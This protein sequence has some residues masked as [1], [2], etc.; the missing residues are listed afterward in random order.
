MLSSV[1]S[2]SHI[3]LHLLNRHRSHGALQTV[4]LVGG[5]K[6]CR[7]PRDHV[8][9]DLHYNTIKRLV[10]SSEVREHLCSALLF[11]LPP[12]QFSSVPSLCSSLK[13]H[14]HLVTSTLTYR[15]ASCCCVTKA[16]TSRATWRQ[17]GQTGLM[18]ML[19]TNRWFYADKK[20]V[21][22]SKKS[23]NSQTSWLVAERQ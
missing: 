17:R 15:T 8:S 22:S 18:F 3:T 23:E 14:I 20:E 1:S 5:T 7:L 9:T 21:R 19:A 2:S 11:L 16:I 10:S 13:H 12:P 6:C 4:G